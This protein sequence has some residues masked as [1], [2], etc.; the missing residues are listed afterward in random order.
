MPRRGAT[1]LGGAKAAAIIE[2]TTTP[3]SLRR[4][5]VEPSR[6]PDRNGGGVPGIIFKGLLPQSAR[7]AV[8]HSRLS[9]PLAALTADFDWHPPMRADRMAGFI[10]EA[11]STITSGAE[12]RHA[13]RPP[14]P[15]EA[16][17]G[18][19]GAPTSPLSNA[20]ARRCRR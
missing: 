13:E 16:P 2:M 9:K 18:P 20:D 10:N 8:G 7:L 11:C 14:H 1:A 3:N 12:A 6:P 4:P 17:S 5:A 19:E 15:Y